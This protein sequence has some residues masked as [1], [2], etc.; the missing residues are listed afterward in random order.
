[1]SNTS[2]VADA[3]L[4]NWV[5]RWAPE[6]TRPYL[7]LARADR[8]IGTWLL[9]IPCWWSS[10]LASLAAAEVLPNVW[11]MALFA[12]GALV[13]RGAGCIYNDIL[14][15]DF[16][17]QVARTSSRPIPSGQVSL[18]NALIFMGA[19][20]LI[21]LIVLLQFNRFTV[22]LGM[23][24]LLIVAIYP[25]MKRVTYF[26]QFV[27]GLAFSWGALLGWA[28]HFGELDWSPALLYTASVFWTVGYDTIYAHQDREDDA[29]LGL[30]STALKFGEHT[31][32]WLT[33]LYGL[34]WAGIFAA[35]AISGGYVVFATAMAL[36]ALHFAWQVSTLDI[37]DQDN[38]LM[39]FRSNRNLGFIVLFGLLADGAIRGAVH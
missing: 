10:A 4:G 36:A 6:P 32:M 20:C 14:D 16:D 23:V 25:L 38:C 29:L 21:G 1:M 31:S 17:S 37:S 18:R 19:L 35:G 15:R 34:A 12:I 13:M 2:P 24:S 3:V 11:H 7:R 33:G 8:P 26:P 5:D 22:L 39:R 28:A 30:K 9:L 27:L